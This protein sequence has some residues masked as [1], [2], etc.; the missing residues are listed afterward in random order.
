MADD[1]YLTIPVA[2]KVKVK[3]DCTTIPVEVVE[4]NATSQSWAEFQTT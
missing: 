3:V 1:I 2:K 4:D